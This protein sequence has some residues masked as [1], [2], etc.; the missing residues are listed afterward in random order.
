MKLRVSTNW[1]PQLPGRLAAYPVE[2]LYGKL[3]DDVIGGCRPSFLL[4]Q[5]S[6]E[7]VAAHVAACH[8]AGLT[9]SYLVNTNCFNNIQ[10][11][12]DGYRAIRELLDWL[13]AIAVDE[14]TIAVPYL[15]RLVKAHYPRFRVK[16]SSVARINTVTRAKQFE[17]M[18]ADELIVDEM[19]NRDFAT[20]AAIQSAVAC[21]LEIIANPCCVWECAQQ[22][23]HVN[24]DGHASQSQS[25][26]DYCYMATPARPPSDQTFARHLAAAVA[27]LAA[28]HPE[29]DITLAGGWAVAAE[30]EALIRGDLVSSILVSTLCIAALFY[31]VYR[32]VMVMKRPRKVSPAK[33]K[34]LGPGRGPGWGP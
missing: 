7:E 17:D 29:A 16:V 6:R 5:V 25:H 14:L 2:S 22:Q 4:P 33:T 18:G 8:A 9:F 27:S 11:T 15:I 31:L 28:A 23:E 19:Q 13:D 26:N 21:P 30:E 12:R 20:L 24:H 1:D 10:Y 34:R 32:R 3:A